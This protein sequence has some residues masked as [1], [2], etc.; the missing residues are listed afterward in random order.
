MGGC[1]IFPVKADG[2]MTAPPERVCVM[3]RWSRG[4]MSG[5]P[6]RVEKVAVLS[7]QSLMHL[8]LLEPAGLTARVCVCVRVWNTW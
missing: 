7:K 5:P 3:D 6:G 2:P 8:L 4:E 1:E